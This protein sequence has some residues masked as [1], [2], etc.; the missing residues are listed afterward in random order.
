VPLPARLVI[1]HASGDEGDAMRN[2]RSF[3]RLL[4]ASTIFVSDIDNDRGTTL[5]GRKVY[6]FGTS[7]RL[8]MWSPILLL[9]AWNAF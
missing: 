5:D 4:G 6:S 7:I 9:R 2:L 3:S 8:L 1:L